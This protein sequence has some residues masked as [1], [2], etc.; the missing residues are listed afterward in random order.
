MRKTLNNL[1]IK[2]FKNAIFILLEV[3]HVI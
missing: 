2:S 1:L 3:P